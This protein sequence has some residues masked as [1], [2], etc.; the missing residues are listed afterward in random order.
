MCVCECVRA[1]VCV[2]VM[3]TQ[4]GSGL[5]VMRSVQCFLPAVGPYAHT[6]KPTDVRTD[7][8]TAGLP[9]SGDLGWASEA[10]H[11]FHIH[12]SPPPLPSELTPSSSSF[13]FVFNPFP[14]F[15]CRRCRRVPSHLISPRSH[16]Q[17]RGHKV[18]KV[19][20]IILLV[21]PPSTCHNH[22][23]TVMSECRKPA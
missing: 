18:T 21:F 14:A 1:C 5:S 9:V 22:F 20:N 23:W 19:L 13:F 3:V 10:S 2:S 6:N 17:R 15:T 16:F 11:G 12:S 4:T 8:Y 7:T